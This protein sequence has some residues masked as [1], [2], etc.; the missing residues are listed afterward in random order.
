MYLFYIHDACF[1]T[2]LKRARVH[3]TISHRINLRC[4]IKHEP[5]LNIYF[6]A[7]KPH[8]DVG[9]WETRFSP[10]NDDINCWSCAVQWVKELLTSIGDKL[11]QRQRFDTSRR[12]PCRVNALFVAL[13]VMCTRSDNLTRAIGHEILPIKADEEGDESVKN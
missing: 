1:K 4:W 2:S 6:F 11:Q 3:S 12:R 9:E 8:Q 10:S 5:N 13:C 7:F